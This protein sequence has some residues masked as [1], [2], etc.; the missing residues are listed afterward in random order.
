MKSYQF[1]GKQILIITIV[2]AYISTVNVSI[3]YVNVVDENKYVIRASMQYF[4]I[5]M[6]IIQ[7]LIHH[8]YDVAIKLLNATPIHTRKSAEIF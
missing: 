8:S 2:L 3:N 4:I 1:W 5:T 6:L 7:I